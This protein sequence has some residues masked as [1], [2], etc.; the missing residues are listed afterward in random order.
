MSFQANDDIK[1]GLVAKLKADTTLVA[2]LSSSSDIKE[3]QWQGDT[4]VYPAVRVRILSNVP[5]DSDCEYGIVTAGVLV[6]SEEAS[7]LEADTIAGIIRTAL[8]KKSFTSSGV[9]F[10]GMR[11]TNLVPAIRSDRNTWR[12]EVLLRTIAN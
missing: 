4:F 10:T 2:A 8:H 12:S 9:A 1:A 3:S 5:P 6:F 11:V 7:S